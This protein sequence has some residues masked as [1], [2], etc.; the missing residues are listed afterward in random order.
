[1]NAVLVLCDDMLSPLSE[2][3]GV[4]V[5]V[6]L[7]IHSTEPLPHVFQKRLQTLIHKTDKETETHVLVILSS[8]VIE[9]RIKETT[10]I[11]KCNAS[12]QKAAV[13]GKEITSPPRSPKI[14]LISTDDSISSDDST[15]SVKFKSSDLLAKDCN[16][17]DQ[18]ITDQRSVFIYS[19]STVY[20]QSYH[21]QKLCFNISQITTLHP[22]IKEAMMKLKIG[23]NRAKCVQRFAWPH[24]AQGRSLCVVGQQQSGKTWCYL[25]W[26]CHRFVMEAVQRDN[27]TSDF[28]PTCI[29]LCASPSKGKEIARWCVS[30]TSKASGDMDR[31]ITLFERS[32]VYAVTAQLARRP[33]G[34][35]LTTVELMLQLCDFNSN[36][37]PI[38]N[39]SAIRC[40]AI[41]DFCYMWRCRRMDCETLIDWLFSFLRIEMDHTQLMIVGRLW[42]GV[43]MQRLLLNM[44]DVLLL[45]DDALEATI[46]GGVKLDILA[47]DSERCEQDII[48]MLKAIKLNEERVV[49][50]CHTKNDANQLGALL[51]AANI[52]SVIMFSTNGFHLYEQWCQRHRSKVLIVTDEIIPKLREVQ[53]DRLVHYTPASSWSRFK[54]R[55]ILFYGNYRSQ[56]NSN[57]ATSTVFLGKSARDLDQ[58]WHVCDFCSSMIGLCQKAG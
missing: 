10:V 6:D 36:D 20:A 4:N 9:E 58:M 49:L 26:L 28:G 1:M 46:Y 25:P 42:S 21:K 34:I 32:D 45:F 7:L 16:F 33:S 24:V 44:T 5:K 19:N 53:I 3:D 23:N 15:V 38:L 37:T 17:K 29:V 56:P 41:D 48:Q 14:E 50:A 11:D 40:V 12:L 35:L 22:N 13:N 43:I 52:E 30:L 2:C 39:P 55:F 47:T 51:L 54:K 31:V 8:P 18:F 57:K 27:D